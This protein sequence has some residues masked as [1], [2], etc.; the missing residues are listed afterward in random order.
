MRLYD[1]DFTIEFVN[2]S[3]IQIFSFLLLLS[4]AG[5]DLRITTTVSIRCY[6]LGFFYDIV[7]KVTSL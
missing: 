7:A 5:G 2:E 6:S 3:G 1:G 4:I